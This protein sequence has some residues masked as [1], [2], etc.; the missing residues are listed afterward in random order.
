MDFEIACKIFCKKKKKKFDNINPIRV[1]S[2]KLNGWD[3][4]YFKL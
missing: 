2:H 1:R 3:K 4:F